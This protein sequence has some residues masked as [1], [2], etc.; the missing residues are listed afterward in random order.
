MYQPAS[1]FVSP[2]TARSRLPVAGKFKSRKKLE[3]KRTD[4]LEDLLKKN[5]VFFIFQKKVFIIK[6]NHYLCGV[7]S[8]SARKIGCGFGDSRLVSGISLFLFYILTPNQ[9]LFLYILR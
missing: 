7:D 9:M 8:T 5:H 1:I 6:N 2:A 4:R 3:G